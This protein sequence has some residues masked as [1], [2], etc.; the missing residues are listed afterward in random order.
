MPREELDKKL[1]REYEDI[2]ARIVNNNK[3]EYKVKEQQYFIDEE[4]NKYEVDGKQIKL[5]PSREEI[6]TAKLLG[7]IYG[8][9]IKIIPKVTIKD[10]I[11]TP[12]Y[13][14]RDK[15]FD[16]KGINGSSR[17]AIYNRIHKQQ[18]QADNFV[19]DISNAELDII[20]YIEQ[21]QS[22]YKNPRT[23]WVNTLIITKDNEIVKIFNRR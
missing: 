7:E 3:K 17:S 8:Q 13:M 6:E 15:K 11:K 12:D 16:R 22:I 18:Q 1:N 14:I 19:I 5:E 4:G 23:Y 20:D 2:T 9:D 10:N 21:A